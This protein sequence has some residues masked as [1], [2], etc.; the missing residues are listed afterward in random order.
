MET[1]NVLQHSTWCSNC[2]CRR[3]SRS[4]IWAGSKSAVIERRKLWWSIQN[5]RKVDQFWLKLHLLSISISKTAKLKL[6]GHGDRSIQTHILKGI[7]NEKST[8]FVFGP[9]DTAIS[10]TGLALCS[11]SEGSAWT[12]G[13]GVKTPLTSAS[14][15]VS[16]DTQ[17]DSRC[18]CVNWE[19][20][21]DWEPGWLFNESKCTAHLSCS[22]P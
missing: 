7:N 3:R 21:R 13:G 20:S 19:D 18:W 5:S 15:W 6:T 11:F 22:S 17:S 4:S 1:P 12:P 10:R 8:Y 16:G 14:S 2:F 9:C